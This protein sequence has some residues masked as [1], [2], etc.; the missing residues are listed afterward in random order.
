MHTNQSTQEPE[1][2]SNDPA[3]LWIKAD[4]VGFFS[5]IDEQNQNLLEDPKVTP[6]FIEGGFLK[7][8]VKVDRDGIEKLLNTQSLD[9]QKP[10]IQNIV[11]NVQIEFNH[12]EEKHDTFSGYIKNLTLFNWRFIAE[13]DPNVTWK[14]IIYGQITGTAYAVV[15]KPDSDEFYRLKNETSV[16]A[17]KKNLFFEN[18]LKKHPKVEYFFKSLSSYLNNLFAIFKKIFGIREYTKDNLD[19]PDQKQSSV[20]SS[21][22]DSAKSPLDNRDKILDPRSSDLINLKA[23]QLTC[24]FPLLRYTFLALQF[25]LVFLICNFLY[26]LICFTIS[27]LGMILV[28]R[29]QLNVVMYL[30]LSYVR[31]LA[32]ALIGLAFSLLI[33]GGIYSR[34]LPPCDELL[35]NWL[36]AISFVLLLS[37]TLKR[38]WLW[39]ILS[40]IWTYGVLLCCTGNMHDCAMRHSTN[41]FNIESSEESLIKNQSNLKKQPLDLIEGIKDKFDFYKNQPHPVLSGEDPVNQLYPHRISLSN[42]A[43]N[44]SKYFECPSK[45]SSQEPFEI[46]IDGQG[47]F[48]FNRTDIPSEADEYLLSNLK[49]LFKVQPAAKILII[50]NSDSIIDQ[51]VKNS[52]VILYQVSL[53]R[54]KNMAEWLIRNNLISADRISIRGEGDRFALIKEKPGKV[55]KDLEEQKSFLSL[56][57]RVDIKLDCPR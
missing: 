28:Q 54:A 11:K 46:Y 42:A 19:L 36:W 51:N 8:V 24:K 27:F 53:K 4:F 40:I 17:T 2:N 32:I 6:I 31:I 29:T 30:R 52:E 50:G 44:P 43:R 57:R 1:I 34:I 56:N 5:G 14:S 16:A 39:F 10:I 23:A 15:I 37:A 25:L 18:F 22:S 7:N 48:D 13:N 45:G 21:F 41:V 55:Y 26:A 35:P 3:T 47:L 38:C 12:T 9:D 33:Y 20:L 49:Q